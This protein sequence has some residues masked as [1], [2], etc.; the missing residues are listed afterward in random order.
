MNKE[1]IEAAK[2]RCSELRKKQTKSETIFWDAVRDRRFLGIKFFRQH[3]I[4]VTYLNKESFYIADFYSR[5]KQV[6]VELDGKSHECQH[7][8]DELRTEIINSLGVKVV[9]FKN[10]DVEI[11]LLQ[12]LKKLE[13]MMDE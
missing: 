7:E 8:Y 2:A 9:R 13:R 1:I 4:F 12:V 10:E 5:E 11:E 6:V 3:P